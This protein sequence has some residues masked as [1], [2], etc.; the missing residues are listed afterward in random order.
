MKSVEVNGPLLVRIALAIAMSAVVI[1][2]VMSVV[3]IRDWQ[4]GYLALGFLAFYPWSFFATL[5]F[6]VPGFLLARR[7][8]RDTIASAVLYG[9]MIGL[10]FGY[11]I[12]GG[13]FSLG[14][15]FYSGLGA[16]AATTFIVVQKKSFPG[17]QDAR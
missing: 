17:L 6:G 7:V 5:V 16:I 10:A 15:S 4:P 1:A 11:W 8:R 3:T 14:L 9:A 2:I 12:S 13:A